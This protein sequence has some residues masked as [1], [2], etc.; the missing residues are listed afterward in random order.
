MSKGATPSGRSQGPLNYVQRAVTKSSKLDKLSKK[1]VAIIIRK[2]KAEGP[3]HFEDEVARALWV[4]AYIESL[5]LEQLLDKLD[6]TDKAYKPTVW[7]L[8]KLAEVMQKFKPR[9]PKRPT[10]GNRPTTTGK[11]ALWEGEN[12]TPVSDV[13]AA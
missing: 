6:V 11:P 13:T 8:T 5:R 12:R 9:G 7:A 10:G 1:H 2:M 4:R 3:Y